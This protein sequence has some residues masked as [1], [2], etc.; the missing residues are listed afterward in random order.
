[1]S[2]K[3]YKAVY[4]SIA[5]WPIFKLSEDRANFINEINEAAFVRIGKQSPQKVADLIATVEIG[6]AHV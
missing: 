6:R 4:P 2:T 1:M 5:D 3:I